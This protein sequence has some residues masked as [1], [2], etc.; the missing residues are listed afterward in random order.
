MAVSKR[1]FVDESDKTVE[2][3]VIIPLV[4]SETM[5][6]DLLDDLSLITNVSE[7][8]LSI[9]KEGSNQE[10]KLSFDSFSKIYPFEIRTVESPKG[11]ARQLNRGAKESKNEYLWF[12]HA[13]SRVHLNPSKTNLRSNALNYGR[14]KFFGS[15]RLLMKLNETGVYFRCKFWGMP[16]GDQGFLIKRKFFDSLSG[17]NEL[18]SF[19]ECHEFAW[20]C[21]KNGILILEAGFEIKTSSRK[22]DQNG[23]LKTS[24]FHIFHTFKQTFQFR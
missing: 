10:T 5:L 2:I 20:R 16:F 9:A 18:V 22:Y 11:R 12:I 8:I 4:E 1:T 7:V 23:W 19:G 14:L 3:S 17:F 13:D 15:P 21:R 6:K 24:L